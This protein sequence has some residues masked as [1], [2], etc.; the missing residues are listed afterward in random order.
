MRAARTR[1]RQANAFEALLS[2]KPVINAAEQCRIAAAN[3][4]GVSSASPYTLL[5]SARTISAFMGR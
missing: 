3:R 2:L 4:D 5:K 1:K